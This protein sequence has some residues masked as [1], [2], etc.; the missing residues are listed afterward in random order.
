MPYLTMCGRTPSA[1]LQ[2]NVTVRS[3]ADR[4]YCKVNP[5]SRNTCSMSVQPA[6]LLAGFPPSGVYATRGVEEGDALAV[7]PLKDAI[8]VGG[9]ASGI[10]VRPAVLPVH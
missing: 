6:S 7:M 5:A 9:G 2:L 10:A 1:V 8:K 3:T 4:G